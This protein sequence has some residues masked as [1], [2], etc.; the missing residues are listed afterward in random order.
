M[1]GSSAIFFKT[2]VYAAA[3]STPDKPVPLYAPTLIGRVALIT[4]PPTEFANGGDWIWLA[5]LGGG[6][7]LI[8]GTWIGWMLLRRKTMKSVLQAADLR[9]PQSRSIDDWLT[10]PR[11]SGDS[12]N[13]SLDSDESHSEEAR[14]RADRNGHSGNGVRLFGDPQEGGDPLDN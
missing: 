14:E 3:S 12:G 7:L 2:E 1:C 11:D 5:I 9:I 10:Q 6:T 13:N 4:I 8:L